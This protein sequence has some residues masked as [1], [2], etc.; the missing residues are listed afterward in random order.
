MHTAA[1]GAPE[2]WDACEDAC[3]TDTNNPYYPYSKADFEGPP[4][5]VTAPLWCKL[6]VDELSKEWYGQKHASLKPTYYRMMSLATGDTSILTC[7][8]AE[9]CVSMLGGMGG[10][11]RCSAACRI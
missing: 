1:E 5:K 8:S 4:P 10:L 3:Q 7:W 2:R 11:G 6:F 9:L